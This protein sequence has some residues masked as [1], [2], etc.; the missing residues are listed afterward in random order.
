MAH[1]AVSAD[2]AATL[3]ANAVDL[4]GHKAIKR[5]PA[6]ELD[7]DSDLGDLA[8]VVDVGPLGFAE[9]S[10]ALASGVVIAEYLQ[11]NA[12]ICSA[13]LSLGGQSR[14][15]RDVRVLEKE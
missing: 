10:A 2:I 7:M 13:V 12:Y 11:R 14:V 6:N 9:C 15:V 4:I 3:I 1:D 8:V 5:L